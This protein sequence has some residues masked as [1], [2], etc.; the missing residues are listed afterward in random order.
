MKFETRFS[1]EAT[2]NYRGKVLK[3]N[4]IIGRSWSSAK[5]FIEQNYAENANGN[6]PLAVEHVYD[7]L[8]FFEFKIRTCF[9][10]IKGIFIL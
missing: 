7:I 9:S 8:S 4:S 3:E 5:F 6:V 1:R 10:F 2:E